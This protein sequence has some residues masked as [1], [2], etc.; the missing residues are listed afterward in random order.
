MASESSTSTEPLTAGADGFYHPASEE[1]L[2]RLVTMAYEGKRQC[3][4]RGAT[5]SVSHAIYADPLGDV[6]NRVSWQPRPPG[7]NV[8][9]MLDRYRSWRVRDESRKVV[10]GDTGI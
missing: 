10:H 7:D 4:V 6:P 2:V 3:R 9:V 1:E 8:D 5:H